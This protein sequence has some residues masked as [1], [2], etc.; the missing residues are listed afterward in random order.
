VKIDQFGIVSLSETEVFEALYTNKISDLHRI[1][2]DN[3]DTIDKFNR[4]KLNNADSFENLETAKIPDV[5]LDQFDLKNQK[6]WFMPQEYKDMDIAA[7]LLSQ[8]STEEEK[9]RIALELQLFTQHNMIPLL[10]YLKYLIDTL[11]ENHVMW[12]VGRG[13]S[14]ASYCLYLIGVHKINS[15]KFDLDIKEFLK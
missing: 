8:C 5:T 12:G 4:A 15:I 9:S 10:Q 14:V 7:W 13:S 1:F 6:A 2:V 3:A 11:R